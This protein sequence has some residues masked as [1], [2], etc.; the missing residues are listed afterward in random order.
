MSVHRLGTAPQERLGVDRSMQNA[1]CPD[2]LHADARIIVIGE[3]LD[4]L[5]EGSPADA[6]IGPKERAVAIP[7]S[8]FRDAAK[9][10]N[11]S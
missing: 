6:G 8:V 10:M 1:N 9:A 11:E 4:A 2:V 7:Y 3:L 5:P